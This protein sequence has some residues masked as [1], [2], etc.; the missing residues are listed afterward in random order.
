[1]VIEEKSPLG[2]EKNADSSLTD[3]GPPMPDFS[4]LT[5]RQKE[6][7][8]F[9]RVKIE[10]RGYGP[11]VREIGKKFEIKSP[12][13]VMCHLKA[14]EKKG[15]IKREGH[16]A[17]AIQLLDYHRAGSGLPFLGKV[18]AGVPVEAI[19][20]ADRLDFDDLFGGPNRFVLQVRGQSMIDNHIDDGDFVVIQQ[21]ETADNGECVVAMIDN[22]VTLKRFYREEGHIRLEP[23]N[24]AMQPIIVDDTQEAKILGVLVGV[25]RKY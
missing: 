22:D 17:R 10:G 13:G 24:G 7:Y 4:Q 5:E 25:M 2:G 20:Q 12:N 1:M 19:D 3:G 11:T 14:L 18:A 21:K 15:L 9:I 23:A 8:E 16:S 6:I